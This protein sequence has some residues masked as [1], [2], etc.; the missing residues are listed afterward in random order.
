ML[1]RR[2]QQRQ[3]TYWGGK[4]SFNRHQSLLDCLVRNTSEF[5]AKL[6]LS[7]TT[8]LPRDFDLQIPKHRTE[9]RARIVWR[10]ADEVGVQFEPAHAGDA[11]DRPTLIPRRPKPQPNGT[12]FRVGNELTPMALIR[13]LKKLRQQNAA[14]HR[15]LL[16][17][18]E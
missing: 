15:R 3:R 16:M 1:E 9:Y 5:G 11:P 14:F 12:S 13:W 8:F 2:K 18:C 6:V 4:I 17:Q 10:R 7:G